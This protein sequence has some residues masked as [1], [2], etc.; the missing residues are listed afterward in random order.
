MSNMSKLE[1]GNPIDQSKQ[2][3]KER[4]MLHFLSKHK[5]HHNIDDCSFPVDLLLHS[6]KRFDRL[7]HI[8]SSY[9]PLTLCTHII[10]KGIMV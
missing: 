5:T 9:N 10:F 3:R 2:F 8:H 7:P 6:T 4:D 1:T